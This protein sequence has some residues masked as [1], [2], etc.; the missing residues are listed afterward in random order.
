MYA[1]KSLKNEEKGIL[2]ATDVVGMQR[3]RHQLIPVCV[4]STP[5]YHA[6]VLLGKGEEKKKDARELKGKWTKKSEEKKKEEEK[7]RRDEEERKSRRKEKEE[8]VRGEA[9]E[10]KGR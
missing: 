5:S 9:Q 7:M 8:E 4:C 10:D 1:L 3:Y 6:T 2:V